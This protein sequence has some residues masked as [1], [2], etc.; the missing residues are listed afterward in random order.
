MHAT[1][2]KRRTN[3]RQKIREA[4]ALTKG[5]H[6]VT[7]TIDNHRAGVYKATMALLPAKTHR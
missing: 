3:K 1:K 6:Q 5:T 7:G 2:E 4:Q